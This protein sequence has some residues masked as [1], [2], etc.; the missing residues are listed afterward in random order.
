MKIAFMQR[1]IVSR[2]FHFFDEIRLIDLIAKQLPAPRGTALHVTSCL[3]NH[4]TCLE[5]FLLKSEKG[6]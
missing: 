2:P 5:P 4:V 6:Y 3:Y 1:Q